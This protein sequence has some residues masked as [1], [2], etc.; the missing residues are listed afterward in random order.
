MAAVEVRGNRGP[1]KGAAPR[2][3]SAP[4]IL[5]GDDKGLIENANTPALVFRLLSPRMPGRQ[6]RRHPAA[7]W[8]DISRGDWPCSRRLARYSVGN[9]EPLPARA[10]AE[11]RL[12]ATEGFRF[13]DGKVTGPGGAGLSTATSPTGLPGLSLNPEI[14]G[15]SLKTERLS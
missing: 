14:R 8:V 15:I 6:S 12:T 10:R 5:R 4:Q 3:P 7:A 11:Y 13:D 9:C 1:E 2:G